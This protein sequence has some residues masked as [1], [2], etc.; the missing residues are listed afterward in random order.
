M[1]SEHIYGLIVLTL[2]ST[3][4]IASPHTTAK[5]NSCSRSTCYNDGK[6][7]FLPGTIYVYKHS[8]ST[9]TTFDKSK[10]T[11]SIAE[12]N[13]KV[14]I[15]IQE[16]DGF[17]FITD[18][19]IH[20]GVKTR[21]SNTVDE[22]NY[23]RPDGE[24]LYE[25]LEK[26]M[27]R[28]SFQDGHISTVC[29]SE[30][31]PVWALNIK[32]AVLSTFQN[33]MER[34]D[35]H[36]IV[37]ERDI[38]GFCP[39][40]Y[41]FLKSNGTQIVV[42]KVK[43]ISEC[44]ERYHMHSIIPTSPYVFQS[45]YHKW[46]PMKSLF[47][48]FYHID[49]H[50][51]VKI[52]CQEKHSFQPFASNE[53][54]SARTKIFQTMVLIKE[55]NAMYISHPDTY[56][57][58]S[59]QPLLYNHKL[60]SNPDS[61][62][63]TETIELIK[64]LCEMS[65][66]QFNPDSPSEFYKVIQ[67]ARKLTY[68][69]LK[70][71]YYISQNDLC[72]SATKHLQSAL[73]YVR[74]TSAVI[75]MKDIL[76]N[77]TISES[78]S[79]DWLM[80]MAMFD[81]PDDQV[82]TEISHLLHKENA[83]SDIL[84]SI[85]SLIH[86]YC[87][88]NPNC[89]ENVELIQAIVY[90]EQKIKENIL[91][92]ENRDKALIWLK[93]LGN[94][95]QTSPTTLHT[96]NAI[97]ANVDLTVD[98]RVA[99][100]QAYR[101]FPCNITRP[102]MLEIFVNQSLDSEVRI[103]AYLQVMRC[104]VYSMVRHIIAVL[105]KEE[106]NQVGS[107]VWT[108]L[109]NL[110]K[111]S[112]PFYLELQTM[113]AGDIN[114]KFNTDIRKFSRNYETSFFL[115]EYGVGGSF[116]NN[117]I[118]SPKSYIPRSITSNITLTL[119]GEYI[120]I[121]EVEVYAEGFENYIEALFK[122]GGVFSSE[123]VKKGLDVLRFV[124]SLIPETL[125]DRINELPN[126][127][128]DNVPPPKISLAIKVFGNE[129]KYLRLN[130]V[131]E[132]NKA[133]RSFDV[134]NI[135]KSFMNGREF[136][137]DQSA[138]FMDLKYVVPTGIGMP[139][140]LDAVGTSVVNL[141]MSSYINADAFKNFGEFKLLTK[142]YPSLAL[143][144]EGSMTMD[145]HYETTQAKVK[146]KLYTSTAFEGTTEVKGYKFVNL[147]FDLPKIRS[148][149][150]SVESE[151]FLEDHK[152][153][154][155]INP[156]R[157]SATPS[158]MS[159]SLPV[160]EEMM[161]LKLYTNYR[162][163]NVTEIIK[164]PMVIFNG[165]LRLNIFLLKSDIKVNKY[166][167]EYKWLTGKKNSSISFIYETPGS[168][169]K[170]YMKALLEMDTQTQNF[171]LLVH[172]KSI[173]LQAL[174]LYRNSP[175][176]KLMTFT[177]DINDVRHLDLLMELKIEN[178]KYGRLY[179]PKLYLDINARRIAELE[180]Q[181]KWVEKKGISQC[182]INL[183]F[184]TTKF[185]STIVGYIKINDAS[186]AL[187]LIFEYTFDKAVTLDTI[188][189]EVKISDRS[190]KALSSLQGT[191]QLESS[192][193]PHINHVT[194][195]IYQKAQGHTECRID[196]I[197]YPNLKDNTKKLHV[198]FGFTQIKYY[199]GNKININL[200][201]TKVAENILF[202]IIA[203]HQDTQTTSNS[204]V[205]VQYAQD[206]NITARLDILMPPSILLN[207][208][209]R[210]KLTIPSG[211]FPLDIHIL[212]KEKVMNEYDIDFAGTWIGGQNVT[213][214]GLYQDH[215]SYYLTSHTLKLLIKS[216]L[217]NDIVFMG[218]IYVSDEEYRM[219]SWVDHNNTKHAILLRHLARSNILQYESYGELKLNTST[220]S[221][222]NLID[223]KNHEITL[224][225]HLDQYRDI[226][227]YGK[228][229]ANEWNSHTIFEVKWDANRDPD[230]KF[231]VTFKTNTTNI[232]DGEQFLGLLV[233]EY[234]GRTVNT[235]LELKYIGQHYFLLSS[236]EW[237][238]TSKIDFSLILKNDFLSKG[239]GYIGCKMLTPFENWMKTLYE[240]SVMIG[241]QNLHTNG[242]VMWQGNQYLNFDVQSGYQTLDEDFGFSFNT[243]VNS[244]LQDLNAIRIYIN[245]NY[246]TNSF[247]TSVLLQI[248]PKYVISLALTGKINST[249]TE[250]IYS[251][252]VTT[253]TP[254]FYYKTFSFDSEV[255][256]Q[257]KKLNG[258]VGLQI[259]SSNF[260]VE[261]HGVYFPLDNSKILLKISTP[262]ESYK[263]LYGKMGYKA[264]EKHIFFDIYGDNF[265]L[266]IE[267]RYLY[268]NLSNYNLK[269]RVN[270]PVD[271]LKQLIIAGK[272]NS[273]LADFRVGWNHFL[274][275]FTGIS[276]YVSWSDFEY[277]L[278]IYTPVEKFT[279]SS[280]TVKIY[281][282]DD[283]DCEIRAVL[284][285]S[286]MIGVKLVYATIPRP[287]EID[288]Y[289]Y[290]E[291]A[292]LSMVLYNGLMEI[293]TAF[294][295]SVVAN[296]NVT[297]KDIMYTTQVGLSAII[298]KVTLK[299]ELFLKNFMDIKNELNV[300]TSYERFSRIFS[301][302]AVYAENENHI[303]SNLIASIVN[304]NKTLK[305][306]LDADFLTT[307]LSD[308]GSEDQ[309]DPDLANN[310]PFGIYEIKFYLTSPFKLLEFCNSS[311]SVKILKHLYETN[312][313]VKTNY[314]NLFV[315]GNMEV[316]DGY[317]DTVVDVDVT[318][319][320]FELPLFRVQVKK[321]YTEI[322]KNV[323]FVISRP[324]VSQV[325]E[326]VLDIKSSWQIDGFNYIKLSG[327]IITPFVVL[328]HVQ[329]SLQY[330]HQSSTK[331]YFLESY[332]NYSRKAEMKARA[333]LKE[334]S[335]TLNLESSLEGLRNVHFLG[336]LFAKDGRKG[337]D[338][339]M[340]GDQ[341]YRISGWASAN[342]SFP[343]ALEAYLTKQ[344]VSVGSIVMQVKHDTH[345]YMILAMLQSMKKII[346]LSTLIVS[347]DEG[348]MT[349]VEI[350]SMQDSSQAVF[351]KSSLVFKRPGIYV[352]NVQGESIIDG[353][354]TL[355]LG[356]VKLWFIG[357]K[358]VIRS[359]VESRYLQGHVN[360]DWVMSLPHHIWG[361][362]DVEYALNKMSYQKLFSKVYFIA[363]ENS[364]SQITVGARVTANNKWTFEANSTAMIPSLRNISFATHLILPQNIT[365][366]Y[367]IVG[368][369]KIH[370]QFDFI[371]HL[372][373]YRSPDLNYEFA[374]FSEVLWNERINGLV[375]WAY[376]TE[377]RVFLVDTFS[378]KTMEKFYDIHNVFD[379]S[380][381]KHRHIS[382]LVYKKPNTPHNISLEVFY[383]PE[384]KIT[385]AM[386]I[387][388]SFDHFTSF[389]NT[390]TP[391]VNI[392]YFALRIIAETSP[393][394]FH[395]HI[396]VFWPHTSALMNATKTKTLKEISM[397]NV[398]E[399]LLQFPIDKKYH[400]GR[401]DFKYE[402]LTKEIIGDSRV[403]YD[404]IKIIEGNF[405]RKFTV[406]KNDFID[407]AIDVMVQNKM[408][409]LGVRYLHR[410]NKDGL[411][412]TVDVPKTDFKRMEVFKLHNET[413]FNVTLEML[414][415]KYEIARENT[416]KV[417]NFNRSIVINSHYDDDNDDSYTRNVKIVLNPDAW[418]NSA[419]R[420]AYHNSTPSEYGKIID[421]NVAY[422][423]R[424]FSII[425]DIETD[426][427]YLMSQMTLIQHRA[428][429]D[430]KYVL[431]YRIDWR[432]LESKVNRHRIAVL[433][434]H[435]SFQK[436][437]TIRGNY[438]RGN[439]ILFDL[440]A[441]Y[442]YAL[443]SRRKFTIG[444]LVENNSA[445][446]KRNYFLSLKGRHLITRFKLDAAGTFKSQ[447][448]FHYF[449]N[450]ITY[451][452][453]YLPDQYWDG[454]GVLDFFNKTILIE[455]YSIHDTTFIYG[456][457]SNFQ[458]T[459]Y[460]N[461]MI[462]RGDD[463]N[464]VG[465]FYINIPQKD[466]NLVINFT[467]DATKQLFMSGNMLESKNA[468]F[469]I[470]RTENNVI[471]PDV[472]FSL[473]LNHS[474]LLSSSLEWR[475]DLKDNIVSALRTSVNRTWCYIQDTTEFWTHYIKSQT[476]ETANGIWADTK[477]EIQE[478]LNDISNF[479]VLEEDLAY[480]RKVFNK[481]YNA[482]EFYLKDIHGLYIAMMEDMSFIDTMGSLPQIVNE[483]W[484]ALGDTGQTIRK[485]IVWFI[486]NIKMAYEEFGKMLKRLMEGEAFVY[487]S[488][489]INSS[490]VKYDKLIR[491]VHISFIRYVESMLEESSNTVA[492]YWS[493]VLKTIEPT[494]VQIFHHI[495]AV[496]VSATKH[497][498]QFLYARQ[499][500]LMQ[501]PYYA[502][503]QNMTQD[504]DKFYKDLMQNDLF[505]NLKKYCTILY[506]VIKT[507]YY[508]LIPFATEMNA[509]RLEI[510]D[511]VNQLLKLPLI[512]YVIDNTKTMIN[513]FVWFCEY[514]DLSKKIQSIIPKLVNRLYDLTYTAV[515]NEM[516]YHKAKT[517]FICDP[518]KGILELEQKLP[519][520]WHAF[521][522]TPRYEEIPEYRMATK[523]LSMFA[524]S[525]VT[526]WFVYYNLMPFM[527]Y[528]NWLPP[529][530]AH[531]MI[532]GSQHFVTFDQRHYDFKGQCSYLLANDFVG[533]EFSLVLNYESEI[534]GHYT[535]LLILGSETIS[536]DLLRKDVRVFPDSI[537][538]MPLQLNDTVIYYEN[539]LLMIE[540]ERGLSLI[541]N[542]NF[543]YCT[544]HVSGWY[545][546]KTAGLLGT[547]DNEPINDMLSS[548][549]YLE[550]DL[551][552]FTESWS[553]NENSCS[554]YPSV[555]RKSS[556]SAQIV[557]IC[558]S[559]FKH[560]TSSLFTCFSVINPSPYYDLCLK[561]F[562]KNETCT[563][564]TAYTEMCS[565]ENLP[566][567]TPTNCVRCHALNNTEI[568][569]GDFL[570]I[571]S[572]HVPSSADIVFIVEA[573][574]C[575]ENFAEKKNV[576]TLLTMMVKELHDV[577]MTNNKFSAVFFGGSGL[578]DE[579]HSVVINGQVFASPTLFLQFLS[580]IQI[581][582]GNSDIFNA[583]RFASKLRFRT[584]HSIIFILFPC[585]DCDPSNM[586][587]D[588]SV[589][590]HIITEKSIK[591][592]VLMDK[593]FILDKSRA[594]SSLFGVDADTAY[595]R[596]DFKVL[597]GDA[598]LR[599]QVK[600]TKNML[601]YCTPIVLESNGSLFTSKKMDTDNLNLVKKFLQV[602]A[603]RIAK[604][605]PPP[606]CQT[607]ECNSDDNGI[608][609]MDCY[610]CSYPTAANI[611]Y[612]FNDDFIP[613]NVI[614]YDSGNG[615]Y[616]DDH[617]N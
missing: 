391:F 123:R 105:D 448:F 187:N 377:N 469:N 130:G 580:N 129:V 177:L 568:T 550:P 417:I 137:Y 111:T 106:V 404:E 354:S 110:K 50:I 155:D 34:F 504:L 151:L 92:K 584:A 390:T 288:E 578:F 494:V 142:L 517:K 460:V 157:N 77:G 476:V 513:Q 21:N 506:D 184:K 502:H 191:M 174:G 178:E 253:L 2:F 318:S 491:D 291:D 54:N 336:T 66:G 503:T 242:S 135:M 259:D 565:I 312:I 434:F 586:M 493:N 16:C 587:L 218:K 597:K 548:N 41:T 296:F 601:G 73:P 75:L 314:T 42:D 371:S 69:A 168:H 392:Q 186:T 306:T 439:S 465:K 588:Y 225:M 436:N 500:E 224:D 560:K 374:T 255:G 281:I 199:S 529:F 591:L 300:S 574:R 244:S 369:L 478:F 328:N 474:R 566:V 511:G 287:E 407:D 88:L 456:N 43:D 198:E 519:F 570:S 416:L 71:L 379:A 594:G 405:T 213:A 484:T 507:K 214:R 153:D 56:E 576:H 310:V 24:V 121:F 263:T 319:K 103:A 80:A 613:P 146:S 95:G 402:D 605:A 252:S 554:A 15:H 150:I 447:E 264:R 364:I 572:S 282:I 600:L 617:I 609:H 167:I 20:K 472:E 60:I 188:K 116:D 526:F 299:D 438:S 148:D 509:L 78:I 414:Q 236:F 195:A 419:L 104:P 29:P 536:I 593:P 32:K 141:N 90:I 234:P 18:T 140:I 338:A 516:K 512:S 442:D 522:E 76:W 332:L 59:R 524:P 273:E 147:E 450:N 12:F 173:Q 52:D 612:G 596:N 602:F 567:R 33:R 350:S 207:V 96:L 510:M 235:D 595:T 471:I 598:S 611:E 256:I 221:V 302:F 19:S 592:H 293:D 125:K 488:D 210:F 115:N 61:T 266:G 232:V 603:K 365:N 418:M 473:S 289:Y 107:F 538:Q 194:S 616:Y 411:V 610:P 363:P 154:V 215:S 540:S 108:H 518:E 453:A 180:G 17:M 22:E 546:G 533:N 495:E 435:P 386:V 466:T 541:C 426:T 395:R 165:P 212:V 270:T 257:E 131:D 285:D 133:I 47:V 164:S 44:T 31:E 237:D 564:A 230:Q 160:L 190:T 443:D 446:S 166:V 295:P 46:S 13:F 272:L 53:T 91:I 553:L 433:L 247:K 309:D 219:E 400:V 351:V 179:L 260:K 368:N 161:G 220:Y 551:Y 440:N 271:P 461:G 246:G 563:S 65:E 254:F 55:E 362:V 240:Q 539:E 326:V 344:G 70:N 423:R 575:N 204:A 265:K 8:I 1:K 378:G 498:I 276:H 396:E 258:V 356:N 606:K 330:F 217:F 547:L 294:Y 193:Y 581:G 323:Q 200:F 475:I 58:T 459:H 413:E 545:F 479:H 145:L 331:S 38:N 382:N 445:K 37:A 561:Q 543:Q 429:P 97:I 114:K 389:I 321:D 27:L 67:A 30:D 410:V 430:D 301:E 571:N 122:P 205:L 614:S 585:T 383:P 297:Q 492:A 127:V 324:T 64:N 521:N 534:K 394:N 437:V 373:H 87:K 6:F 81:R 542:M 549:G 4:D 202:K 399:I 49:H 397:L 163:P 93:S 583:I 99:G 7:K 346:R 268:K 181:Y 420:V 63:V 339:I 196:F 182:D 499:Q 117:V 558:D 557:E 422:P 577:G 406:Y 262:Y 9:Q 124:R 239:S 159:Y 192:A 100:V 128:T 449:H 82:V 608:S 136:K 334:Q 428:L 228:G 223:L 366:E 292:D 537:K 298:I 279:Y 68:D 251:G 35:I 454:K 421:I 248:N 589:I 143:N 359:S 370:D 3:L 532:V 341:S 102:T 361:M 427:K 269:L 57:I 72:S 245:H 415:N 367:V 171:T 112:V 313:T 280:A 424:N 284:P 531:A 158:N 333:H 481:S 352:V 84:L 139:L 120:N 10:N 463:Q 501:S 452:R 528:T 348:K 477:P 144:L 403:V 393:L 535:M 343:L 401:F 227:I 119:F 203:N 486:D 109:Q 514:I 26:N 387:F 335:I 345:G 525:N 376:R 170:H 467:P 468:K 579:P 483:I 126:V 229:F 169:V 283:I 480:F 305:T 85:T 74:T 304:F 86:T 385:S 274:L 381:L 113:L 615:F 25:D 152:L 384:I 380:F 28:F 303:V 322:E 45:K 162:L 599:K 408:L 14:H 183:T 98:I 308:P 238:P 208:D 243:A 311:M 286:S 149:I 101:R 431:G 360:I 222:S 398:G 79:T 556:P 94:T 412:A 496:F 261:F 490:M 527:D 349:T 329:G 552:K 216:H 508:P 458:G 83:S 11:A 607:C 176:H 36:H 544:F 172:G 48:C 267:L 231:S 497:V 457:Y 464:I 201:V 62:D 134:Y 320:L 523:L 226:S 590:N 325:N 505:T 241:P 317:F 278:Q 307:A 582:N 441:E 357:D 489:F 573:K 118:F 355:L 23:L 250:T 425:S 337:I 197:N 530:R 372:F 275:G 249:K 327:E 455:K 138:M 315:I 487:V 233:I 562:N 555:Q 353:V 206:K 316:Y 569:E 604:T 277:A 175:L 5:H 51:I 342:S 40:A 375:T 451:K 462:R 340:I 409:P 89:N 156:N 485:S 432:K 559:Y 132:I 39:T 388:E 211:K 515:D 290:D 185:D 209:T 358:G 520:S 347:T 470:W 189:L 444:C 482:N